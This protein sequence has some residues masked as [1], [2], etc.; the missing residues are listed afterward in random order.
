MSAFDQIPRTDHRP[1]PPGEAAFAYLNRSARPEADRVRSL[2]D[3]WLAV[4]PASH[5]EQIVS[6][7]RS[8]I[9][10]Q[11]DSAFFE[12]FIYAVI[13]A[14]GYAV[15]AVE[16]ALEGRRTSPDFLVEFSAGERAYVE[17][18]VVTGMTDQ[19]AAAQRRLDQARAAI[20]ATS[21]PRHFLDL[22]VRGLPTAP[23][24]TAILTRDLRQ[25]IASLPE[26]VASTEVAPFIHQ[27]NGLKLVVRAWPR[28]SPSEGRSIGVQHSPARRI[29][30][31]EDLRSTLKK[32]A[33]RYGRLDHPFLVAVTALQTHVY[34]DAV[35]DALLGTPSAI[36][37]RTSTDG[38]FEAEDGRVPDGVWFGNHGAVR[39]GLSAILFYPRIDP[40]NFAGRCGVLVRHPFARHPFPPVN[41]G[42]DQLNPIGDRFERTIGAPVSALLALPEEWPSM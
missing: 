42:V 19:E 32:K 33:R 34:E 2:I 28:Q 27:E 35:L 7:L 39:T 18:A 14:S 16:P 26:G 36:L 29:S 15:I 10:A 21:S 5:R 40:W 13:L 37:R 38:R 1:P 22:Y 9:D 11:H 24:R 23:L 31:H 12:L 4:Y 6:R 20:D 8:S 17:C 3:Q 41:L 25:W 30:A